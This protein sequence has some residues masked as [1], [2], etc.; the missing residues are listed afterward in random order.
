MPEIQAYTILYNIVK[1][2]FLL[3]FFL[4]YYNKN[5]K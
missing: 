1:F 3:Q 2:S 4:Y 5:K